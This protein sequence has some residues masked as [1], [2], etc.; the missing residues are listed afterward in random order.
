MQFSFEG[1]VILGIIVVV[2][3]SKKLIFFIKFYSDKIW[4]L[5]CMW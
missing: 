1:K 4:E 3:L 2:I 5:Q